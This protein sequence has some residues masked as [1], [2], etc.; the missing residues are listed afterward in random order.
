MSRASWRILSGFPDGWCVTVTVG[1]SEVLSRFYGRQGGE[2]E[3]RDGVLGQ[4][5]AGT[6]DL[7]APRDAARFGRWVRRHWR[8]AVAEMRAAHDDEVRS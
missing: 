1:G 7:R 3:L 4:Q 5:I 8:E 2:W 6:L